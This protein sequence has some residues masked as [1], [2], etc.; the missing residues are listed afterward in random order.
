MGDNKA[1]LE[2]ATFLSEP[3]PVK[4][5]RQARIAQMPDGRYY[6]TATRARNRPHYGPLQGPFK[7]EVLARNDLNAAQKTSDWPL[8]FVKREI[9]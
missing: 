7:D 6:W 5:G 1:S 8:G 3:F 2:N 4:A 9:G